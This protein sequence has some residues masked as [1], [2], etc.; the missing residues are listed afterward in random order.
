MFKGV[1]PRVH[2]ALSLAL[3]AGLRLYLTSRS[4]KP[5]NEG[6]FAITLHSRLEDNRQEENGFKLGGD[7]CGLVALFGCIWN[8]P[9]RETA[10]LY[11]DLMMT[12]IDCGSLLPDSNIS[13]FD[14]LDMPE[15]LR[16]GIFSS[17]FRLDPLY[18]SLPPLARHL[19]KYGAAV[20]GTKH[21]KDGETLQT[22]PR[23]HPAAEVIPCCL[24]LGLAIR[25]R[26]S[27]CTARGIT[28]TT[29]PRLTLQFLANHGF[30][31]SPLASLWPPTSVKLQQGNR[32]KRNI[33]KQLI[34]RRK[35]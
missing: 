22:T 34:T 25:E 30:D 17:C 7:G 16:G 27:A 14:H 28:R 3:Y 21:D 2:S 13:V 4:S 11:V 32:R 26:L 18:L 9:D 1:P 33:L 35:R 29:Q 23:L 12:A 6:L 15:V 10:L 24:R 8:S 19:L 31:M 5:S 20:N